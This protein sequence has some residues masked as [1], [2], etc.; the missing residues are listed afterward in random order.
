MAD[1][2]VRGAFHLEGEQPISTLHSIRDAGVEADTVMERLGARLDRF[3]RTRVS[4]T[5]ELAGF[6][7]V[8]AQLSELEARLDRLDRRRVSPSVGLGGGLMGNAAG[9]GGGGASTFTTGGNSGRS[10]TLFGALGGAPGIVGLG[11]GL[12]PGILG[13]LGGATSILGSAGGAALGAGAVGLGGLG[14]FGA[15]AGLIAAPAKQAVAG[16][17]AVTKAQQ[18]YTLAVREYGAA[19]SQAATAQQRLNAQIAAN[20]QAA[21]A[22]RQLSLF[23]QDFNS[24]L[25]PARA[26]IYRGISGSL[27][28]LRQAAPQFGQSAAVASTAGAN[29]SIQFSQFLAAPAQQGT[30]RA[31]AGSFAQELPIAERSL[32]NIVTLFGHLAVDATP[33]FH[34]A[35][36]WVQNWTSGMAQSSTNTARVQGTMHTLVNDAKDWAKLTGS[37]AGLLKDIFTAG[38]PAGNSMVVSLADTFDRW[39]RFINGH[40]GQV[41][42]FFQKAE[43]TTKNIAS[44]VSS[45]VGDIAKLAGYLGPIFDRA[46]QFLSFAGGLGP[47][48]GSLIGSLALG[49]YQGLRG[50]TGGRLPSAGSVA[51]SYVLGRPMGG[52]RVGGGTVIGAGGVAAAGSLARSGRSTMLIPP[53]TRPFPTL[54]EPIPAGALGGELPL[55]A[56]VGGA[57]YAGTISGAVRATPEAFDARVASLRASSG[58]PLAGAHYAPLEAGGTR[59][60]GLSRA[61]EPFQGAVEGAARFALPLVGIMALLQG[62]QTKGGIGAKVMGGLNSAGSMAT[63]G[64]APHSGGALAGGIGGLLLGRGAEGLLGRLGFGLAGAGIG[65]AAQALISPDVTGPNMSA[66]VRSGVTHA[67]TLARSLSAARTPGQ[68]SRVQSQIRTARMMATVNIGETTGD[69]QDAQRKLVDFLNKLSVTAGKDAGKTASMSWESAFESGVQHEGAGKAVS[70]LSTGIETQLKALGPRGRLAFAQNTEDWIKQ[71]EQAEPKLRGPLQKVSKQIL[72]DLN[73]MRI[74]GG[75]TFDDLRGKITTVNGQILTGSAREWEQISQKLT[76]PIDIAKEKLAGTFD[77]IRQEAL[78]S[79]TAMGFTGAQAQQI[80]SGHA[81]QLVPGASAVTGAARSLTAGKKH[82]AM[83]GVF[84]GSGLLDTVGLPG[85]G[86]AAPGEAWIAN[87]WTMNDLSRATLKEYGVTAWQMIRDEKRR[88]SDPAGNATRPGI[89]QGIMP[90]Y[91]RGGGLSNLGVGFMNAVTAGGGQVGSLPSMVSKAD[92]ITAQHYPYLWGGGHNAN[93]TGPYDCS[94]AVSSVLHAGG[95]LSSPEVAQQFMGYG[96]PGPGEVTLFASPAHVYMRMGQ[97]YF[98]TSQSNPGGG[99]AWFQGAPR[100]GFVQRHVPVSGSATGLGAAGMG[101]MG[102]QSIS[103]RSPTSGMLGVPGALLDRA[104]SVYASGLQQMINGKLAT[105]GPLNVSGTGGTSGQNQA[106]GRRMMIA[107]GWPATQWPS[108]QALWTQES[109]WNANAVNPSSGAAGIAQSLGHGAVQLG[110]ARGQIAWGLGYIRDRYGSPAAA[111]AHEQAFNW[112]QRGGRTNWAGWNAKGADFITN[113]PT[114]LGAGESGRE[115]VTV[116][117]VGR[118]TGGHT[119]SIRMENVNF[120]GGSKHELEKMAEHVAGKIIDALDQAGSGTSDAGLIGAA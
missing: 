67:D 47:G 95:V 81:Q 12:S 13:L 78:G 72:G 27:Y 92:W 43:T 23:R 34:E 29:A 41:Q 118:S 11:L 69:S 40:P 91:A 25:R 86:A 66:L 98:G 35:N 36:V 19:S 70:Q 55:L 77:Q 57:S 101:G 90:G 74:K 93:F 52:A 59:A 45:L 37:A 61:V 1:G 83:G 109:G 30:L 50:A 21:G 49:G 76:D 54:G 56:A 82:H 64:L 97:N 79:L 111:E 75:Q 99:A 68:V 26:Q 104:G 51:G 112:Y 120:G 88:H 22:S 113:G 96:L 6:D 116:T 42:Q 106:L 39:D 17:T 110:D 24:A 15:G 28:N 2:T 114:L 108:L 100:A 32:Q 119:I 94:G 9:G 85:G 80:V 16:L 33:F 62:A 14:T 102:G 71:L 65:T 53:M 8:N 60:Y 20:P 31:L 73:E 87:R 117:P 107:A 38:A 4:A 10:P 7:R 46:M 44:A 103:L 84:G 89:V 48:A 5:V 18:A 58:L 115:R 3:G 63:L 105:T